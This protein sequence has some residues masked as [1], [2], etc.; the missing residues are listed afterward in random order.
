MSPYLE[1]LFIEVNHNNKLYL[2]GV[3][4]RIPDTNVN[5][6]NETIN[7]II[8]PIK[9][10]YEI[11]LL[12]DFNICPL[13]DNNHTNNFRNSLISNNLFPTILEPT[14]VATVNRNGQRVTTE[15][16]IDN[17]FINT[18]LDFK[19]GLIYS[20]ISDHYPVF[21]SIHHSTNQQTEENCT[22]KYRVID[23]FT[24][25]KFKFAL[26]ISLNSLL[27]DATDPQTAFTKF[28]L[29]LDELYNKYFPIK[30]K[31]VSKKAQQ[32]PWIN[33]TLVNRIKIKDKLCRQSSKGRI[34][35]KTYTDF[36]NKLTAQI[37]KAKASYFEN[38]FNMCKGN[39]KETWN[40]INS[41]IKNKKYL[42]K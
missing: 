14:R 21:I 15:S 6:F 10:N 28:Y 23:E 39:I 17:I 19:S 40:T 24:I 25:R 41:T 3:T 16:L 33:Q 20:S 29:L 35:R 5:S 27:N 13:K 4:Y 9:N 31:S 7:A 34:D 8:E 22:I 18:Q 12:G 1:A 26:S 36:R 11:I 37:R 2:V 38:R 32:K 30:T 42:I